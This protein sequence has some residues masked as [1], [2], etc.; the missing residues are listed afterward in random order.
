MRLTTTEPNVNLLTKSNKTIHNVLL[1]GGIRLH[2]WVTED[3]TKEVKLGYAFY[4]KDRISPI[5]TGG[6]IC[7]LPDILTLERTILNIAGA[8]MFVNWDYSPIYS[9]SAD[10]TEYTDRQIGWLTSDEV[11]PLMDLLEYFEEEG[12]DDLTDEERGYYWE[13]NCLYCFKTKQ[14]LITNINLN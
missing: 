3:S 9:T 2:C 1:P 6:L 7:N 10:I 11:Y 12:F 14:R 4:P 13:N 8:V 5:L